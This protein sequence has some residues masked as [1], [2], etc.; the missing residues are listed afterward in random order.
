MLF[1]SLVDPK[2]PVAI[3]AGIED[4][5]ARRDELR[6][7]GLERAQAFSWEESTRLTVEAYREAAA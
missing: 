4:A 3:A 6:A 7:R 5:I 2:E 1:R